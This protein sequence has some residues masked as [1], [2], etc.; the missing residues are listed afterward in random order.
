MNKTTNDNQPRKLSVEELKQQLKRKRTLTPRFRWPISV[1]SA[2]TLLTAAYMAEVEY[3]HRSFVHDEAT[4]AHIHTMATA[5]T[6]Q[7]PRF[8]IILMGNCGNGKT[9]LLYAFRQACNYLAEHRFILPPYPDIDL[10]LHLLDAREMAYLIAKVY[11]MYKKKRDCFMLGVEDVGREA[12]EVLD[13]GNVLN[14]FQE[15]M[16][17]RYDHQLFTIVTTNCSPD[18]F[19]QHYGTRVADRM[20]EMMTRIVFENPTYRNL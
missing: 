19:R 18:E 17:Y 4:R 9:T 14:P 1:E 8:G 16:E 11:P 3:R 2:E 5:L 20:N 10:G 6:A 15:L 13:Y 12:A 7:S